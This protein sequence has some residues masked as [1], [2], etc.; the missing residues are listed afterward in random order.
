MGGVFMQEVLYSKD[1]KP[2]IFRNGSLI[3][4]HGEE[5]AKL[6]NQI[7]TT[8]PAKYD[9]KKAKKYAKKELRKQGFWV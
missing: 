4:F 7:L 3:T 2:V 1:N 9:N 5:G 8:K 6:F